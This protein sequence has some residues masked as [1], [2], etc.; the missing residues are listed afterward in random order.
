[1]ND[2]KLLDL[3][4][5][6]TEAGTTVTTDLEP[7]ITLDLITNLND[8]LNTLTDLHGIMTLDRMAAGSTVCL[9]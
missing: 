8:N 9:A 3:H 6:D 1:M 7:G 5:F 4:R 2:M